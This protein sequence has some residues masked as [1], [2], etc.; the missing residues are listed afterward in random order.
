MRLDSSS[1]TSTFNP[2]RREASCDK[3]PNKEFKKLHW[4]CIPVADV[5]AIDIQRFRA[6][7]SVLLIQFKV[8]LSPPIISALSHSEKRYNS[9]ALVGSGTQQARVGG[10]WFSRVLELAV[11]CVRWS[12]HGAL[13]RNIY[14]II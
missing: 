10:S 13:Y 3:N 6:N 14:R 8:C 4:T 9:L 11:G 7:C 5:T 12:W 2:V 1:Y